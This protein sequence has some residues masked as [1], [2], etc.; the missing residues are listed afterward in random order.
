MKIILLALVFALL[1]A[2][3]GLSKHIELSFEDKLIKKLVA[4]YKRRGR[5]GRPLEHYNDTITINYNMQ[6][7]Q[8]M[9]LD[10]RNQVLTLN[11]WDRYEEEEEG[12]DDDD[13][14][15]G[16]DDDGDDDGDDDED[17]DDDA[18]IK[19]KALIN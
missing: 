5:W 4:R 2:T 12:G 17:D 16:D 10:E 14:D 8:I 7:I 9:D 1:E 19:R 11:V 13:D 18:F 6:L 3:Y 15:D